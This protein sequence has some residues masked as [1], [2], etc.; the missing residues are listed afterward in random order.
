M[1]LFA[2]NVSL[3][4]SAEDVRSFFAKFGP[5]R[6]DVKRGY[7]FIDY[8]DDRDAEDARNDTNGK[9]FHGMK[10]NV[11]WSKK[12]LARNARM[13]G[14]PQDWDRRNSR[15]DDRRFRDHDR[16]YSRHR[17]SPY[18]RDRNDRDRDRDRDR[19]YD[20]RYRDLD[21]TNDRERDERPRNDR[22]RRDRDWQS[23]RNQ[24]Y[25]RDARHDQSRPR[26]SRQFRDHSNDRS[27]ERADRRRYEDD[28]PR[29]EDN[30]RHP[31]Q[32]ERERSADPLDPDRPNSD[33]KTRAE[34]SNRDDHR[35]DRDD[36]DDRDHRKDRDDRD[37]QEDR[38]D[39]VENGTQDPTSRAVNED[40]NKRDVSPTVPDDQLESDRHRRRSRDDD[41]DQYEQGSQLDRKRQKME[42]RE[43]VSSRPKREFEGEYDRDFPDKSR[44]KDDHRNGHGPDSF[45]H[46]DRRNGD[47]ADPAWVGRDKNSD[48]ETTRDQRTEARSEGARANVDHDQPP[49]HGAPME[50]EERTAGF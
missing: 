3:R 35:D 27:R 46:E 31:N 44:G 39:P 32:R 2:G 11:E 47:A 37:K 24:D 4:A 10:L 22:D 23:D 20:R 15:N 30:D 45:P 16:D 28:K 26:D 36:R 19:D 43:D 38:P 29:Y 5:C 41:R 40:E 8:D 48:H 42:T 12:H 17:P 49:A 34:P 13:T 18:G 33:D 21:R 25:D 1:S 14:P 7:A 9:D 6:V 50:E